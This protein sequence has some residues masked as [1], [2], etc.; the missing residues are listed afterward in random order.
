MHAP[1]GALRFVGTVLHQ[2]WPWTY[3]LVAPPASACIGWRRPKSNRSA[4]IAPG[5][6]APAPT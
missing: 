3:T 4:A 1:T 2:P 5:R 6:L